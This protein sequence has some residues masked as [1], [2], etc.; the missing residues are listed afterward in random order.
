[1]RI[2]NNFL[3]VIVSGKAQ[4]GKSSTVAYLRAELEAQGIPTTELMI[5]KP[6]KDY[7]KEHFGWDGGEA[8]KPR[9]FLQDIGNYIRFDMANPDFL[10]NRCCED[11]RILSP[12]R[13]I[14]FVSDC[15][16]R[17]ELDTFRAHF[18]PQN[19]LTIRV[20]RT[21]FESP[22]TPAEQAHITETDLDGVTNWDITVSADTLPHLH[23]ALTP[24]PTQ[25]AQRHD[26]SN[27]ENRP[28]PIFFDMDGVM[29]AYEHNDSVFLHNWFEPNLFTRKQP[30][31]A[32]L[33]K[34]A[35]LAQTGRYEPYILS[36]APCHRAAAQ[37]REWLLEQFAKYNFT[38]PEAHQ[39]YV[40]ETKRKV[41]FLKQ[42][43]TELGYY[44]AEVTLVED[45]HA[46]LEQ[47]EEAGFN[48][49]HLSHF[50]ADWERDKTKKR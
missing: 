16:F 37:K 14:I 9:K 36:V 31:P 1:M 27:P 49:M 15:R 41:D 7:A 22:L 6:I 32:V 45:T 44:P 21:N 30:V 29:A 43:T 19:L 10:I 40:G 38:I 33:R 17:N 20:Q 18:L 28:I 42:I 47:A 12:H 23:A 46:T 11:A 24:L 25:I 39:Y 48:V 3:L 35:K 5:A 4:H 13:P 8:T 26:A 50:L 34:I 2:D